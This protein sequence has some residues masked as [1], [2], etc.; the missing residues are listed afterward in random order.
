MYTSMWQILSIKDVQWHYV[1]WEGV[2]HWPSLCKSDMTWLNSTDSYGICIE[3]YRSALNENT[4]A[5]ASID[6]EGTDPL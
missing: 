2:E 6:L 5:F 4:N 3:A 1:Q